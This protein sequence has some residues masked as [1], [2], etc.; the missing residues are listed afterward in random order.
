[1]DDSKKIRSLRDFENRLSE[2]LSDQQRQHV[3]QVEQLMELAGDAS[4][5]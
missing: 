1:M 2:L 4:T 3:I 5:E